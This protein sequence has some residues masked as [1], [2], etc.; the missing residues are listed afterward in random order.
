MKG[1]TYWVGGYSTYAILKEWMK[2]SFLLFLLFVVNRIHHRLC[3][4]VPLAILQSPP[5]LVVGVVELP[6]LL[7]PAPR[8]PENVNLYQRNH[9]KGSF[10]PL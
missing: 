5:L 7:L 2:R 1:S 3:Y 4:P 8:V 10:C 9:I 6:S